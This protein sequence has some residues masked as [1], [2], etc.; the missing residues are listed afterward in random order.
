MTA[1]LR[2]LHKRQCSCAGGYSICGPLERIDG[3]SVEPLVLG[4]LAIGCYANEARDIQRA[5][6]CIVVR[7]E[8]GFTL[9]KE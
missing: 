4:R 2:C 9:V 3:K 5:I 8:K 7:V 1:F 6:R